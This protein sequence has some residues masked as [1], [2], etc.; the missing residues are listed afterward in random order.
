M[1][2]NSRIFIFAFF[3]II[4][5]LYYG[6]RKIRRHTAAK[7]V[8]LAG[9]L[10]FYAFGHV[11]Y[12][13]L[14][15]G[16]IVFNYLVYLI[17]EKNTRKGIRLTAASFAVIANLGVLF[18]FKYFDFFISNIN[19]VFSSDIALLGVA[20]PLGIS[21]F[22]FQ[23]VSFIVDTYKGET[24]GYGFLNYSLFVSFFPQL[25]AGPIVLHD[26]LI[27]QFDDES[28]Y[29]PKPERF[30]E[31]LKYFVIGLCKKTIVADG[32]SKIVDAGFADNM[33]WSSP[34]ALLIMTCYTIQLYF[35][36]SG[37]SDMALGLGRML[38]FDLPVN[39]D[40]PLCAENPKDFWKRWHITLNRFLTRY[41]YVPLGGSR[42]GKIRTYINIMIV[43]AVSGLW[44][45]AGWSFIEW[46][47]LHG[48]ALCFHRAFKDRI[49]KLPKLLTGTVTF[50]FVGEWYAEWEHF[51]IHFSESCMTVYQRCFAY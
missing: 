11:Y 1:L 31:G 49:G 16:S 9:S 50:V 32:F 39:F 43:F 10:F 19:K 44:H 47:I 13:F 21:F 26:E 42:K 6:L 33:T 35:D 5:V 28:R 22:T 40:R 14:L 37:Y 27:P 38:G 46:G 3:P 7:C 8:L 20:L 23:Q 24:H 2:F 48:L 45:G 12:F 4:F 30:N 34:S 25:V 51:Y 36:F 15:T 18:Y 41:V 17:L 29:L